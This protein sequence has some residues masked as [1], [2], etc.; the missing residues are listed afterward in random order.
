MDRKNLE[1]KRANY[2]SRGD[3]GE[4][5]EKQCGFSC[6]FSFLVNQEDESYRYCERFKMRV[7]DFDS[8]KYYKD[9]A[10]FFDSLKTF[11]EMLEH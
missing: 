5:T 1:L 9:N 7:G 6:E 8:C 2:I 3:N 10:E 4:Y 11:S